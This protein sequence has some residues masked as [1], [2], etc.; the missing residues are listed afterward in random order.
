V[1][2]NPTQEVEDWG[3][4]VRINHMMLPVWLPWDVASLVL[5][6]RFEDLID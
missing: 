6:W 4:L 2:V 1:G 3:T 5:V